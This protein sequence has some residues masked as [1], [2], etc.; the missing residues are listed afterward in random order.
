MEIEPG[1]SEEAP[2][3]SKYRGLSW[4]KKYQGWRVRIYYAGKQRHVGRYEDEASAAGAYDKAAVFLYGTSAITNFGLDSC[5]KDPTEAALQ[6]GA[7]VAPAYQQHQQLYQVQQQAQQQQEQQQILLPV[8]TSEG[9]QQQLLVAGGYPVAHAGSITFAD[10]ES[11]QQQQQQQQEQ[12]ARSNSRQQQQLQVSAMPV[13]GS[14]YVLVSSP[15]TAADSMSSIS[16]VTSTAKTLQCCCNHS[17][18]R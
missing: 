14:S 15:L 18:S 5:L 12:L 7:V 1:I 2:V 6:H 16:R 17:S 9:L 3:R 13:D 11:L 8:L 4:D 10:V